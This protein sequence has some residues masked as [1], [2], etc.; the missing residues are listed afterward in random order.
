MSKADVDDE[1]DSQSEISVNKRRNSDEPDNM[2]PVKQ[3]HT[4]IDYLP[5]QDRPGP[6]GLSNSTTNSTTS[7]TDDDRGSWFLQDELDRLYGDTVPQQSDDS[8][9]SIKIDTEVDVIKALK[10]QVIIDGK[11]SMYIVIRRGAPLD[12]SLSL[13]RRAASKVTPEHVLR[14]KFIGEDGIDDGALA[15]EFL[16]TTV[17]EIGKKLFPDGS[18]LYSTNDI[19]NGNY[20]SIGQVIAVSLSQ[21][22]PPPCFLAPCVYNT[23]VSDV[24]FFSEDLDKHLTASELNTLQQI[25]QNVTEHVDLIL[26][27]GYTGPINNTNV[28]SIVSAVVVGMLS[29]RALILKEVQKGMELYCLTTIVANHPKAARSLFVVGEQKPVD[30]DYLFSLMK[31]EFSPEGTSRHHLEEAVMDHFQDFIFHLEDSTVTGYTEAL[32]WKSAYN[33]DDD[34][35]ELMDTQD[36]FTTPDMTPA[37]V[38]GWLTGQRHRD[39]VEKKPIYIKFDHECMQRNPHHRVCF[40]HVGACGREITFPVLHMSSSDAF[41]DVFLLAFCRSQAFSRT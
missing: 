34:D 4:E 11:N 1:D 17:V 29:R 40:P 7:K 10:K 21:G 20:K 33:V 36:K 27:H 19:H 30:A 2:P 13:W 28:D 37:A 31:S 24:D 22:G 38:M 15:R 8:N 35:D 18:L 25:K 9:E 23:L 39:I 5:I 41:K 14:L 16:A 32:A 6:S 12:R 26:E 3:N